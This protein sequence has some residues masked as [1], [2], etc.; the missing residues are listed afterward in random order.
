MMYSSNISTNPHL[1][2]VLFDFGLNALIHYKYNYYYSISSDME[3]VKFQLGNNAFESAQ[4]GILHGN[5]SIGMMQDGAV[6]F[7]LGTLKKGGKKSA[8]LYICMAH[9][10]KGVKKLTSEMK[11][12]DTQVEFGKTVEYWTNFLNTA[13]VKSTG[14]Q[15]VDMLYKRSLLVF[16][17]MA[18][19]KTGG[20]MAAPEIDE[21]FTRS[22]RYA[23]CWG[24]DAAFITGA[25]DKCGLSEAV[26]KFYR[27]AAEIQD[28]EGCWQ[29]RYYMDGN[30]APSWGLQVDETGTVLWGILK[31]YEMTGD[32]AFLKDMW[33]CVKKG[34]S[35]LLNYIDQ[36]TGLPWLSF[37]LW[38]E[39]LG[40]HAY[41][42]AAVYGGIMAGAEIGKILRMPAAI[43][44]AWREGALNIKAAMENNFLKSGHNRFIRSVRTKLNPWGDEYTQDKVILKVN[45]KDNYRDFTREDWTV[46]I[47]LLGL[48]IPFGVYKPGDPVMDETAKLVESALAS[49]LQGGLMR[50]ENDGYMGG[51]P[52]VLASLWAAL[53]N[54]E[55]KDYGKAKQY[56]DFAVRS[57]T[58]LGLL[59]EQVDKNTGKPAWVIPLT[60]SHAMFVLVLDK[61]MEAGV[62]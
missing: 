51:N 16:K 1:S 5:D 2:S 43:L 14:N 42:S 33:E 31:H 39:R 34:V 19:K 49:P 25:L 38:E 3:C 56:F 61:L 53:Y 36:D 8:S 22:G 35:F 20:I 23:Y 17:L 26:D 58:E 6:S 41:S 45:S 50:Y 40:E 44:D 11:H 47:S 21:E 27:W 7:E 59:P 18:D 30:L 46:D 12:A 24:R 60:W 28:E 4:T 29:Q 48:C 37:D 9:T 52:W 54:I 62:L 10:L 32:A 15:S 57:Q 55:K 13:G